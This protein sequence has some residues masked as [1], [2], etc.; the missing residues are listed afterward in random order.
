MSTDLSSKHLVSFLLLTFNQEEFVK[1]ALLGALAQEYTPLEIVISDD[2]STDET[3]RIIL[4]VVQNYKGSHK[5]ILNKNAVNLGIAEHLNKIIELAKG[6]FLVLAAG[7]DISMPHRVQIMVDAWLNS[8]KRFKSIFSNA[9]KIDANNC[10]LELYFKGIPSYSKSLESVLEQIKSCSFFQDL[11][12]QFGATLGIEKGLHQIYGKFHPRA[13]QEDGILALRALLQGEI[14]YLDNALIKYRVHNS[15]VSNLNN[16]RSLQRFKIFEP[17]YRQQQL[18]D[19]MRTHR[20]NHKLIR[21][22]KIRF[23]ISL[24]VSLFFKNRVAARILFSFKSFL[25]KI[26]LNVP[27]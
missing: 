4:D 6:E 27:K 7:D 19:A 1:D 25:K 10:E 11:V 5:V 3:W 24:L 16:W 20:N 22:L 21:Y 2:N 17:Y 18:W 15:S 13:I 12:W 8:E 23:V 14:G 9:I 26:L